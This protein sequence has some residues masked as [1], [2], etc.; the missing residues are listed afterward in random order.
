MMYLRREDLIK[1][2]E[3][4]RIFIKNSAANGKPAKY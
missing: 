3:D 2:N 1:A 4:L